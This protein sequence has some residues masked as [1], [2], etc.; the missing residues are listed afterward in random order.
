M[1]KAIFSILALLI[2]C[3]SGNSQGKPY[4]NLVFEGAGIRGIAY[5]G[6]LE[7]LDKRAIL[8]DIKR[9]GGTSAGAI[10]ATAFAI[11]YSPQQT[12]SIISNTNFGK[13]N[14][15]RFI[16]I[17][18]ISRMKSSFGWYRG[19]AFTKWIG[20]MLEKKT[21]NSEITF[22]QLHNSGKPDLYITGTSL[23]QQKMVVFSY[24][25]YPDMKVKD[26]V[27]ISMSVPLYF[28]ALWIDS[29][30]KTY[31]NPKGLK[32]PNLVM[33]GGIIGN[34]PIHIFDSLK[35][36]DG[37]IPGTKNA[38]DKNMQTIGL[39]MDTEDQIDYDHKNKG[40]APL[41][42]TN[43]RGYI[44]AFYNIVLENLN[45]QQLDNT[46]WQRTISIS[47]VDIGPRVKKL[48]KEQKERLIESGRKGVREYYSG[49]LNR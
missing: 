27:R 25:N 3:V 31:S 46:D 32:N 23:T 45:R 7:E 22:I 30:G 5:S 4:R 21:G 13:F 28:K 9:V 35:Y 39:R 26:A 19:Q 17:G 8:K 44:W 6:A 29:S 49:N 1:K 10:V 15:G 11:G 24:E 38:S 20:R 34:F 36:Q 43:F 42:V 2:F 41:E 33:D 14:D 16:F 12:D 47:S 37:Y 48:S 40:L 18:G